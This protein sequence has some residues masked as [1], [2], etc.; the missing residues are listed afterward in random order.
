MNK[1][2]T[3]LC[4]LF[5]QTKHAEEMSVN[6]L[7]SKDIYYVVCYYIDSEVNKSFYIFFSYE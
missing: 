7:Y 2:I 6:F 4:K 1:K 3:D 5:F